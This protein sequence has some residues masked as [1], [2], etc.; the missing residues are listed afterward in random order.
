MIPFQ[1][2]KPKREPEERLPTLELPLEEERLA[3]QVQGYP[4]TD[5]EERMHIAF[6]HNGV[7]P[8]DI[9]F[10]PSFI[11][12]RNMAG[13]IRP[14]FALHIGLIQVWYADEEFFHKTAEQKKKDEMNDAILFNRMNGRI[15]F[16]IRIPGDD[17][18]TQEDADRAIAEWVR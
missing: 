12:G 13:E 9:E 5:I 16:P 8:E 17:L 4:A 7:R 18:D 10:Q 14:D 11:A 1:W 6:L 3:G 15:E 2:P